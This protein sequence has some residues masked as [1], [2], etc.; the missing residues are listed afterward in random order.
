M[1]VQP[2]SYNRLLCKPVPVRY[3]VQAAPLSC[4]STPSCH[5]ESE[6]LA[7]YDFLLPNNTH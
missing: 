5:L 3:V 2:F 1:G 6:H 7:E 4:L